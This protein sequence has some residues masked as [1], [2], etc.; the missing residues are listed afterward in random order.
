M[1]E[2]VSYNVSVDPEP[3]GEKLKERLSL[4]GL[5]FRDLKAW[6]TATQRAEE[7]Q[8]NLQEELE[9]KSLFELALSKEDAGVQELEAMFRAF[10]KSGYLYTCASQLY[11]KQLESLQ[12]Q[13]KTL[14]QS[15]NQGKDL[16][17]LEQTVKSTRKD[18]EQLAAKS[19]KSLCQAEKEAVL[20]TVSS[21][22]SDLGYLVEARG[23]ALKA[24]CRQNCVW[25]EANSLG[26]LEI[27]LS[28][29]SGLSCLKEV[30][31]LEAMLKRHGLV[32]K[33]Q[34]SKVHQLKEGGT[35]SQRLYPLF[36]VFKRAPSSKAIYK[37]GKNKKLQKGE[38]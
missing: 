26:G 20:A 23:D 7:L 4:R 38:S 17:S 10:N 21:A 16:I 29:F 5:F 36:P 8:K 28:G 30:S 31:R 3:G 13:I 32:L 24:T 33:R 14:R 15:L 1:S 22:L 18:L 12:A 35:L 37:A 2:S 27:D 9:R 11:G 19:Q 25:A 6:S 34:S